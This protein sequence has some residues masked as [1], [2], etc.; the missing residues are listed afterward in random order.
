M[1]T[2]PS[3]SGPPGPNG[4]LSCPIPV[5]VTRPAQR[6]RHAIE[7]GRERHLEIAWIARDHMDIDATG[8]QQRS[9]VGECR[10][11]VGREPAP[12]LAQQVAPDALRRLGGAE[13][14]SIHGRPDEIAVDPLE[15][16]GDRHDRDGRAVSCGRL[17]HGCHEAGSDERSRRVVDEDDAGRIRVMSIEGREAGVDRFLASSPAGDDVDHARRQPG[18]AGHGGA[19]LVG[20]HDDHASDRRRGRE[21]VERPGEQR[22]SADLHR[23][24][25]VAA[26]PARRPRGD[27]DHVGRA[28]LAQ[29]SR[30]WAKI[31]RPA[32]VWSTRVTD[33]SSSRSM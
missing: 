31:I 25:V 26:H 13:A 30:G 1:A 21:G 3:A 4:W 33:T 22:S 7:V 15:G 19:T 10:G 2:P 18:R 12:G 6:L 24:L 5:R 32:T 8:F 29:S 23:E 20:R 9:L 17:R 11:A 14:G 28:R 16:L 27:H